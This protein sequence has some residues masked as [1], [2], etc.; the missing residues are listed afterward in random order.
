MS[1]S[2]GSSDEGFSS[3]GSRFKLSRS[4]LVSYEEEVF[5]D[6]HD[7]QTCLPS[8]EEAGEE[9][10]SRDRALDIDAS[11]S[12]VSVVEEGVLNAIPIFHS[13]FTMDHLDKNLLDSRHQLDALRES[14]CIP[15]SVGMRLVHNKELPTDPPKGHVMFYT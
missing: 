8:D 15:N 12:H 4:S 3:S 1:G 9:H 14:C 6:P 10:R 11:T 5:G 7:H 2:E 13:E